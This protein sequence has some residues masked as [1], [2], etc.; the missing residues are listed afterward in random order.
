MAISSFT[1]VL[2]AP[3]V[4]AALL[5]SLNAVDVGNVLAQGAVLG[6]QVLNGSW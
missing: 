3:S 6:A 4:N 1:L 5:S 2:N